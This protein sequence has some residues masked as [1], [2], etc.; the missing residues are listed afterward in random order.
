MVEHRLKNSLGVGHGSCHAPVTYLQRTDNVIRP[1]Q[2]H[3]PE[4][5][6]GSIREGNLQVLEHIVAVGD[7]LAL[8]PFGAAATLT[9]LQSSYYADS[10]GLPDA[11]KAL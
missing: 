5:F 6:I 4:S 11:L 10:F 3:N 7:L 2:Q 1:V 9:Q 8:Q